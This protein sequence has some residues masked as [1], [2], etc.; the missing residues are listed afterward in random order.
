MVTLVTSLIIVF[1]FLKKFKYSDKLAMT[2][3]TTRF[4]LSQ[5]NLKLV[6]QGTQKLKN[7][8]E[9]FFRYF[10]LHKTRKRF[11]RI[12]FLVL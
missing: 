1:N 8:P 3:A 11:V 2:V 12:I 5:K 10:E 7:H 6:L 9:V 4:S